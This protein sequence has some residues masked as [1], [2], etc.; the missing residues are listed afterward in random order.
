MPIS[1][2]DLDSL[3]EWNAEPGKYVL[4]VYLNV[5]QSRSTNLNRGYLRSLKEL[6][7][8]S[9][10]RLTDEKERKGFAACAERVLGHVTASDARSRSLALFCDGA[11]GL[12]WNRD[13]NIPLASAVRWED[14]PYLRPLLEAIDEYER[15]GVAL[16]DR[17]KGRLFTVYLGKV[18]EHRDIIAPDKRKFTKTA[19]KDTNLSQPNLQRREEEHVLWHLKEVAAALENIAARSAFDRLV[20]AGPHEVTGEL[21]GLL[22]KKLQSLV[23]RTLPLPIDASEQIVLKETMRVEEELER[24]EESELVE[25]LITAASKESQAVIDMGPTL[26]AMRLGRIHELVYVHDLSVEG[27][28]CA[29]CASL[30]TD[31]AAACEYCGGALRPIPDIVARLSDMV[32]YSGGHAENVRGPAADRLRAAGRIGAFLRF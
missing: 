25:K 15:Y 28:Q 1:R 32:F 14:R 17:E 11:K 2:K 23:T 21:R 27:R 4:S 30:F 29:H 9:E 6:L 24:Q 19:S 12:F 8:C 20:L 5:D 13:L 7:R 26:D 22:S 18:E 3:I 31:P 16:V 10:Q